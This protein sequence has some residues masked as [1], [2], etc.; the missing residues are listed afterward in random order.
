MKILTSFFA[1]ALFAT[2]LFT[3]SVYAADNQLIVDEQQVIHTND[4]RFH[5]CD[6]AGNPDCLK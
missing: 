1:S 3:F 2:S 5:Q 4:G 6:L